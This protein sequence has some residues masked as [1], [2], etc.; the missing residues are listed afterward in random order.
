MDSRLVERDRKSKSRRP[1]SISNQHTSTS[2]ARK[3]IIE[4]QSTAERS[5]RSDEEETTKSNCEERTKGYFSI[6]T[7]SIPNFYTTTDSTL[8]EENISSR[9]TVLFRI[10]FCFDIGPYLRNFTSRF[11]LSIDRSELGLLSKVLTWPRGHHGY[12]YRRI[13]VESNC[14][15]EILVERQV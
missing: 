12:V 9:R 1:I 4:S 11:S 3:N 10:G 7:E 15:S 2:E 13:I 6:Y 14:W 5:R 8:R